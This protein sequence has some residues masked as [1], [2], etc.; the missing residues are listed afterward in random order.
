MVA[1]DVVA[2]LDVCAPSVSADDLTCY[3]KFMGTSRFTVT[4]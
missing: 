2:A 4:S 1:S 3:S